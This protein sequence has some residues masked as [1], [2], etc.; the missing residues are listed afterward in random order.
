MYI[1]S[2]AIAGHILGILFKTLHWPGANVLLVSSG[3]LLVITLALLLVRKRGPITVQL[4]FPALLMGSLIAVV[5]GGLFKIMHWP[6]ANM[7]LMTG[8]IVCAV[9]FL[10][11]AGRRTM[12]A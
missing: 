12:E 2:I 1:R 7:L 8:L 10:I 11:P 3:I 5:T 4:Y 6:G 9:W